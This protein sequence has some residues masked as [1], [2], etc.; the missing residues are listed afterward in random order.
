[1][2]RIW[3]V[4]WRFGLLLF[5]VTVVALLPVYYYGLRPVRTWADNVNEFMQTTTE[6]LAGLGSAPAPTPTPTVDLE[7]INER[8][9]GLEQRTENG[10]SAFATIENKLEVLAGSVAELHERPA[11]APDRRT[12]ERLAVLETKINRPSPAPMPEPPGA[13]RF[14]SANPATP[15]AAQPTSNS[16]EI[17]KDVEVDKKTGKVKAWV[18]HEGTIN[19]SLKPVPPGAEPKEIRSAY[20]PT[21]R[22]KSGPPARYG[23]AVVQAGTLP[24]YLHYHE[25]RHRG[26]F[27]DHLHWVPCYQNHGYR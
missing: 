24:Y 6:K 8:I 5:L 11:P 22:P 19:G 12:E 18:L 7:P 10:L 23:Q 20:P 15:K 26:L 25:V 21:E 1:M 9:A 13:P 16:P 17:Y 14:A 2:N 3:R 4:V 27:S